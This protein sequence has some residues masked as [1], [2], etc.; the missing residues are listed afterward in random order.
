MKNQA[1]LLAD[2]IQLWNNPCARAA[3]ELRRLHQS[4]QEGWRYAKELEQERKRLHEENTALR[5]CAIKYL[6]YLRVPNQEKALE[7]DMKN[8]DMLK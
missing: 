1:L 7:S 3:A 4:E 6:D 5:K 2:E 8:K